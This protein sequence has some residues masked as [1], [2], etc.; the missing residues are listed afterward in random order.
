MLNAVAFHFPLPLCHHAG[1]STQTVGPSD[2]VG[3]V[4]LNNVQCSG[5]EA[6]LSQCSSSSVGIQNCSEY[7]G[8]LCSSC[9]TSTIRLQGGD[10]HSGRVEV[11][12]NGQWGTVC[13][14]SWDATDALVACRQLGFGQISKKIYI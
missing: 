14:G 8:V 9:T 2:A 13:N 11:C 4:I 1:S 3:Q 5:T 12:L 6:R 7:A 10:L